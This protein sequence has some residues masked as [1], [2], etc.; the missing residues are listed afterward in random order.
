MSQLTGAFTIE[1]DLDRLAD[2]VADRV[3]H[4]LHQAARQATAGDVNSPPAGSADYWRGEPDANPPADSDP[5]GC[6]LG[7][8]ARGHGEGIR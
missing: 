8:A 5:G 2:K 7:R 6:P 1:V 3:L 4:R